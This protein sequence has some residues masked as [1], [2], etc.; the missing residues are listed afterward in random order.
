MFSKSLED[1]T[2]GMCSGRPIRTNTEVSFDYTWLVYKISKNYIKLN[3]KIIFNLRFSK[4]LR[5]CN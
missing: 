1:G 4:F 2:K 5:D 3:K